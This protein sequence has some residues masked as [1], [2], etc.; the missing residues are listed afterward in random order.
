MLNGAQGGTADG[1]DPVS[2]HFVGDAQGFFKRVDV[3]D[4]EFDELVE[5]GGVGCS[6][7]V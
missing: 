4:V 3:R 7:Q 5:A 2:P 6:A 1:T